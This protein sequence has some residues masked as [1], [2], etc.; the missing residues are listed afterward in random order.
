MNHELLKAVIYDQHEIIRAAQIVDRGYELDP[1]ANYV[2]TG[3]RRAGK[4]TLLYKV[5]QDLVAQG[6]G[7]EQ[8]VYV[9]FEDER[10]SEFTKNDFN[11]ILEVQAELGG[12]RGYFFLDEVQN[13]D[14]W[15]KFARRLADAK[16]RAYITGSNARMLGREIATTLGGRYLTL[17]VGTY[18]FGEYLTAAGQ[19]FDDRALHATKERGRILGCFD[20]YLHLGGFPES[21]NYRS[22]R[23]YVE[24]VYQKVLLGDI[25]TR[26]R[27]RDPQ[28]LRILMKKVAETVRS[29]V[30]YSALYGMLKAVGLSASKDTVIDYLAYARDAYLVFDVPNFAAKFSE[31]QGNPKWYFSDNGLLNL[32]LLD[33]DTALL[34]NLV[35]IALHARFE[36]GLFFLKSAKTGIDLDFYVP[37]HG[38]AV[39][40]AYSI[41]GEARGQEV[42]ALAK[43]AAAQPDMKRLVIVTRDEQET[44]ELDG[45]MPVEV[46]P[47]WRFLLEMGAM[48]GL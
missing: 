15:E 1:N 3:L 31:R 2:V 36:D 46:V 28:A 48:A 12:G 38:L 23:E 5:A 37:E 40:V 42:G 29:E 14:G 16:E 11:D 34:E 44:V 45:G 8:I 20:T 10:L 35:A 26:N 7:W 18:G 33:K 17:R 24:S 21:L 13:V 32:F 41:A 27:I 19:P 39:Q 25:A 47:A 6:V 22:P 4:S 43:L 30:S 9:N